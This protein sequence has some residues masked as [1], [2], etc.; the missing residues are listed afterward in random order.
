MNIKE[1]NFKDKRDVN[2]G[3]CQP[4]YWT[5]K[6]RTP[7][8]RLCLLFAYFWLSASPGLLLS[9][10]KVSSFRE[11]SCSDSFHCPEMTDVSDV[12]P[13]KLCLLIKRKSSV[14]LMVHLL[15]IWEQSNVSWRVMSSN[16]EWI[17]QAKCYIC[18]KLCPSETLLGGSTLSP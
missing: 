18:L 5:F 11:L 1:G 14:P 7:G 6:V 9:F 4:K 12:F 3:S 8:L 2:N 10:L 13:R 17:E 15:R 16:L